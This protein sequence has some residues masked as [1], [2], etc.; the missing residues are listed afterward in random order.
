MRSGF[1]GAGGA[2]DGRFWGT[3]VSSVVFLVESLVRG[4]TVRAS[5]RMPTLATMRPSRRWGTQICYGLDLGHPPDDKAVAKMG[6][7]NSDVGHPALSPTLVRRTLLRLCVVSAQHL[8]RLLI[9]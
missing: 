2:L 3:G 6:H 1:E 8:R 7:P 4:E 5:A 9:E